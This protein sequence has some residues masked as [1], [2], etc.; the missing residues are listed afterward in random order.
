[1]DVDDLEP[2]LGSNPTGFEVAEA[3]EELGYYQFAMGYQAALNRD[4]EV[5]DMLGWHRRSSFFHDGAR[6]A[7]FEMANT[8]PDA[9]IEGDKH[10]SRN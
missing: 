8:Q 1:M 10:G 4:N 6:L 9:I 5:I 2:K 3:Y 7:I